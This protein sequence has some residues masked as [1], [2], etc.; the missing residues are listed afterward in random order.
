MTNLALMGM[1]S[2]LFNQMSLSL[3]TS[4]IHFLFLFKAF[5]MPNFLF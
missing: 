2:F 4:V 5:D 1:S 3:I